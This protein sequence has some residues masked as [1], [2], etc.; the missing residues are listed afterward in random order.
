VRTEWQGTAGTGAVCCTRLHTSVVREI[1]GARG[2][3]YPFAPFPFL[4]FYL[5]HK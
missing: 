2:C 3:N 5:G 1:M 4:P